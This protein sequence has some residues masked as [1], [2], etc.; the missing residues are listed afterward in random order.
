MSSLAARAFHTATDDG[1][2]GSP[3]ATVELGLETLTKT[4]RG[5]AL[6]LERLS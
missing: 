5:G 1:P 6:Q 4:L 2:W 3:I